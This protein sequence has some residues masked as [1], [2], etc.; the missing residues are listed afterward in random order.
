MQTLERVGGLADHNPFDNNVLQ[1]LPVWLS[2][3][4]VR[5][6]V[7]TADQNDYTPMLA[8]IFEGQLPKVN[9]PPPRRCNAA[10]KHLA[11]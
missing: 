9:S 10:G 1:D 2:N 11:D 7:L 5:R 4:H 3:C 8:W 6:R